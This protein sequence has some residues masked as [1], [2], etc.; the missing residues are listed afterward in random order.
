MLQQLQH[1]LKARPKDEGAKAQVADLSYKGPVGHDG[2]ISTIISHCDPDTGENLLM[3]C[4][5]DGLVRK[6]S[7][8]LIVS[9]K[10]KD[11][12]GCARTMSGRHV[13]KV[14]A[15]MNITK[16]AA[17]I[18]VQ[19]KDA[20]DQGKK[21]RAL[22]KGVIVRSASWFQDVVALGTNRNSVLFLDPFTMEAENLLSSHCRAINGLDTHPELSLFVTCSA[23]RTARIWRVK[24]KFAQSNDEDRE[25]VAIGI[26]PAAG[27]SVSFHPNGKA[28]VVGM[29]NA[30][31]VV[32]EWGA[33]LSTIDKGALQ[34]IYVTGRKYVGP[35]RNRT[36]KAR[37]DFQKK[38]IEEAKSKKKGV[39]TKFKSHEEISDIKYSPDGRLLAAASRDN[40]IHMYSTE[41]HDVENSV[42][43][44]PGIR[45]RYKRIGL[46]RGHSSFLTHVD[47]TAD[48]SMMQSN[49]GAYEIL[50]WE[51]E[52]AKQYT[53]TM[54]MR[55]VKWDTWSAVLGWPVQ[56]IWK[57]GSDGTDVNA[58]DRSRREDTIVTGDDY[59]KVNLYRFPCLK[60]AQY[61]S[62]AGHC[63]HVLGVKFLADDSHVISIG[64][65]DCSI[66]QWKH[67]DG[68]G[69]PIEYP[70]EMLQKRRKW[71]R[72]NAMAVKEEGEYVEDSVEA[73]KRR[74]KEL[75]G[76]PE[77]KA[78]E[79]A[80]IAEER[81][82]ARRLEEE[83]IKLEEEKRK[84]VAEEREKLRIERETTERK[85]R[86][87]EAKE[88]KVRETEAKERKAKEKA[89]EAAAAEEERATAAAEAEKAKAAAAAAADEERAAAA[90]KAEK[91]KAAEAE[92]AKAAEAEKA[93]A[94]AAAEEERAT[95]A[96][97][98]EAEVEKKDAEESKEASTADDDDGSAKDQVDEVPTD[99]GNEDD[100]DGEEGQPSTED[101]A[102]EEDAADEEK[103]DGDGDEDEDEGK[104]TDVGADDA[105]EDGEDHAGDDADGTGTNADDN[106]E[107]A[108]TAGDA[109][110]ADEGKGDDEAKNAERKL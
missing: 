29:V 43:F 108:E 72:E 41:G 4:G 109:S 68:S 9:P 82:K 16:Y 105:A 55:A 102:A 6:W 70:Y 63:S 86:E 15:E 17:H 99:G 22:G 58:V 65:N 62:Y 48:S 47:W 77:E 7:I 33:D 110:G 78:E 45:R 93:E 59:F 50:Y 31:F 23:D 8:D 52:T 56:G 60:K 95:A 14:V 30:E 54:H 2:G 87:A 35:P 32:M 46:C 10:V 40:Y 98:E 27:Q 73:L 64:G 83:E 37:T 36:K 24:G 94:A 76:D 44:T 91:A 80:R 79:K 97:V 81:E 21:K 3:T 28:I 69:D 25:A 34:K 49:D 71:K 67:V 75:L 96:A 92:K 85:A 90:A 104:T 53:H 39:S 51:A 100:D 57:P 12:N 89:K 38:F 107:A 106:E 1:H 18:T 11:V 66:F 5:H 19:D 74:R 20:A 42:P 26:L 13:L 61:K 88:R 101:T 103:G 84:R